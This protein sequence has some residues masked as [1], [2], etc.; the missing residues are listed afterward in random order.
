MQYRQAQRRRSASR[1]AD[2]LSPGALLGDEGKV[3]R[4]ESFAEF[5]FHA[6]FIWSFII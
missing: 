2:E 3:S 1:L 4:V 6:F 5:S